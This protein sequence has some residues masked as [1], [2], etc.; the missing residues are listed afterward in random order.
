M[1]IRCCFILVVV[2][3]KVVSNQKISVGDMIEFLELANPIQTNTI[4]QPSEGF[5]FVQLPPFPLALYYLRF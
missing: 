4:D 5:N 1:T 3:L 2:L